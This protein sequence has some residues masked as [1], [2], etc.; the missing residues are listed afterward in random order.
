MHDYTLT[1]L[2]AVL[3]RDLT[4]L[5]AQDRFTTATLLAHVAEVDARRLYVGSGQYVCKWH[6]AATLW[7]LFLIL[8]PSS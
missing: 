4:A 1:N 8:T 2:S 6:Q 5:V 7:L 3:L